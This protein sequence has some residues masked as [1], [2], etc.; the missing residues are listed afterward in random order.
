[1]A[2]NKRTWREFQESDPLYALKGEVQEFRVYADDNTVNRE[3]I[4][5]YCQKLFIDGLA[6]PK[7][8]IEVW[9]AM[10]IPVELQADVLEPFLDF[11]RVN[12]PHALNEIIWQLIKGMR[13]KV[14]AAE[15][16]I[17][18][19][20]AGCVDKHY[21]IA[22]LLH[23]MYPKSP[24]SAWGWSRVGWGWKEWWKF[25]EGTLGALTPSSAFDSLAKVLEKIEA[26]GGVPLAKQELWQSQNRLSSA[27]KLLCQFG[28]VS[29]GD[30]SA[31]LDATL[32]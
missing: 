23:T 28:S 19:A 18:G 30:L 24:H 4:S 31:C 9:A 5:K 16:A 1:M 32:V 26:E 11:G 6:K 22:K 17:K 8:W 29:E 25:L 27:R 21:G 14:P 7:D 2:S 15:K 13:V 20:F 3:H 12:K 10:L